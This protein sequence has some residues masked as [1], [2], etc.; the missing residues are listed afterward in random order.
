[1]STTLIQPD[2]DELDRV[3]DCLAGRH[4]NIQVTRPDHRGTVRLYAN[5]GAEWRFTAENRLIAVR[6]AR[7]GRV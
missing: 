4:G 1:M 2:A 6:R 5:D 3:L 7:H